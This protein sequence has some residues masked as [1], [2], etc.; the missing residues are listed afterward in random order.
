MTNW[1]IPWDK[2]ELAG[3]KG[4]RTWQTQILSDIKHH[5]EDEAK[6]YM[7]CRIAVRSGHGIGKSALVGLISNWGIG[8]CV[9]ARLLI[10]A[11][12]DTQLRTR[13]S[14]EVGLWMR[15]SIMGE[16]FDTD[17]MSIRIKDK[18]HA[19]NWR[20]DFQPWSIQN[21][22]SI[23]GL[24]NLRKRI[25]IVFDEAS[26]IPDIIWEGIMGATIGADTEVIW[27][28][29]GNP[30]KIAGANYFHDIWGKYRKM[31]TRYSIDARDVEDTNKEL[32]AE[33]LEVYGEESDFFK[34][35][36]RGLP[37]K[38]SAMQLFPEPLIDKA[39]A[40][41][42]KSFPNDA[43][44]WGLDIARF[45]GDRTVLFKRRGFDGKTHEIKWWDDIDSMDLI[46]YMNQQ[47]KDDPCD[48]LFLD[49][50]NTGGAIYDGL[51]KLGNT[52]VT[53][54]WFGSKPDGNVDGVVV[55]N[56]R[57]EMYLRGK[58][59]LGNPLASLPPIDDL[60]ADLLNINYGYAGDQVS[61]M[62]ERKEDLRKRNLPSPD[63]SDAWAL[64]FAYGVMSKAMQA[65]ATNTGSGADN[66]NPAMDD[67]DP[68]QL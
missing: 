45:G 13:T 41:P 2:G 60:R 8:T 1:S 33:W 52:N 15:R 9:D 34:V 14:P 61:T 40:N 43:Y 65:E 56:K 5:Y 29:F 16:I 25:L 53:G 55:L 31:W 66:L 54:V 50:G 3:F 21:P 57:A 26:G 67:W 46:G 17:T 38:A 48:H 19:P 68:Q 4:P 47:L 59:W 18:D 23:Q 10:T 7:P 35:R 12:T 22:V 27:L 44:V 49:M 64:T 36:V 32:I 28:A 24:H 11:N 20:L 58:S 6:R 37:P 39:I 63:F 42:A 30:N 51:V 62:L